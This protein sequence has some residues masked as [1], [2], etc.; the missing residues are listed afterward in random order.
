MGSCYNSIVVEAPIDTVWST[1]RDFHD[2]S[3]AKGVATKVDVVGDVKGDQAGAKRIINDAFHETLLEVN[4]DTHTVRYIIDDGPGAVAKDQVKNY[5]GTLKLF[6]VT[7]DGT[8]FVEWTSSYDSADPD[9]VGEL[10]NPVYQA[11]LQALKSH[12]E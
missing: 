11:L 7:A 4:A 5:I 3:W 6:T 10:C 2:L 8:T 1:V 12:V 9:A